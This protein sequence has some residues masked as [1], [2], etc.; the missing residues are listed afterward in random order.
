MVWPIESSQL[1]PKVC[2]LNL[3][4]SK[5]KFKAVVDICLIRSSLIH[6]ACIGVAPLR[7]SWGA[8]P[9]Q[10]KWIKLDLMSNEINDHLIRA[11]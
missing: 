5:N 2:G 9:M 11:H 8:T 3:F 7:Q 4:Y 10:A 1:H 6:F